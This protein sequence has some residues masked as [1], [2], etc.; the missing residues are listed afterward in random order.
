MDIPLFLILVWP[1]LASDVSSRHDMHSLQSLYGCSPPGSLSSKSRA[2]V[3]PYILRSQI[4]P[5]PIKSASFE[6]QLPR[7]LEG[8]RSTQRRQPPQVCP[9]MTGGCAQPRR[10]GAKT[11]PNGQIRDLEIVCQEYLYVFAPVRI[12]EGPAFPRNIISQTFLHVFGLTRG[13]AF[14]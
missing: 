9:H 14:P 1:R 7:C 13:T 12:H 3:A 4:L 10:R 11:D 6:H 5:H 2:L 8:K